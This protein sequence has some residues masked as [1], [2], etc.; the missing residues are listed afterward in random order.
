MA[1]RRPICGRGTRAAASV[2][3]RSEPYA[4]EGQSNGGSE[5]VH[6]L[7]S[8][9]VTV[10]LWG[11]AAID[12]VAI[13]FNRRYDGSLAVHSFP[14]RMPG[15]CPRPADPWIPQESRHWLSVEG[16]PATGGRVS[17][18]VLPA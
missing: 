11:Q 7:T 2:T 4:G 3:T 16:C 13:E 12:Q 15:R 8:T 9:L 10:V 5:H 18:R 14:W 17:R 1:Y 6:E